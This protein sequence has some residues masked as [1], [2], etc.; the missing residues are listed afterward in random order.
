[1]VTISR[2]CQYLFMAMLTLPLLSSAMPMARAQSGGNAITLR[3]DVQEANAITGVITARGNVQIDY[4]ARQIYATSAQAR[5]FSEERRIVLSGDVVVLQE[6][7][8]LRAETVTYLIDEGRFVALPQPQEQ[9][10]SVYILQDN[11]SQAEGGT[12]DSRANTAAP[13]PPSLNLSPIDAGDEA[14]L[15]PSAP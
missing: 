8:R 7:N 15:N 2:W 9:V 14:E 6:G 1:M 4:P 11:P 12:Q 13:P 3:S 10:E 5:Y